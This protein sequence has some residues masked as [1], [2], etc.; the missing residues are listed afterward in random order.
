MKVE[1]GTRKDGVLWNLEPPSLE[2]FK[3]AQ[4]SKQPDLLLKLAVL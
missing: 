4:D 3:A 2:T 1:Q